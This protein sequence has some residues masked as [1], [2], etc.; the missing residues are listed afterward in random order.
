MDPWR[1]DNPFNHA[2][3][4]SIWRLDGIVENIELGQIYFLTEV[5]NIDKKT[6]DKRITN[7]SLYFPT[8]IGLSLQEDVFYSMRPH[9][10]HGIMWEHEVIGYGPDEGIPPQVLG[11]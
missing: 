4:I 10:T 9:P 5:N 2:L 7:I 11:G 6:F 3:K 1:R 8:G